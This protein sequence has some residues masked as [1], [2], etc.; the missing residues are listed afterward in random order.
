MTTKFLSSLIYC[1]QHMPE[2][3]FGVKCTGF[4]QPRQ[5]QIAGV[6]KEFCRAY[7]PFMKNKDKRCKHEKL[8]YA[9]VYKYMKHG[10]KF[11]TSNKMEN[12]VKPL[13]RLSQVHHYLY[14]LYPRM[15]CKRF[16]I[17]GSFVKPLTV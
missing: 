8:K 11:S 1:K 14:Q 5:I 3:Q 17:Q 13:P 15:M 10:R 12:G 4:L 2:T 9:W 7:L 16:L 6:F